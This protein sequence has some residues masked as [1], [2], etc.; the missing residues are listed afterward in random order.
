[1]SELIPIILEVNREEHKLA[2]AA[3]WT[4]ADVLR[5]NLGLTGTKLICN[6]ERAP[7]WL[8]KNRRSHA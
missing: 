3:D 2:V 1:M 7:F 8:K 6:A 4:L 5:E